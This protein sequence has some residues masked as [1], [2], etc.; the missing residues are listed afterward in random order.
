[1]QDILSVLTFVVPIMYLLTTTFYMTHFFSNSDWSQKAKTPSLVVT[2]L[3]HLVYLSV[4]T[5]QNGY[6]PIASLY[7]VMTMIA[8]TLIA[9]YLIIELSTK[10]D[11]TGSF[12]I[13]F[14][15]IFQGLSSI[16]INQVRF[17]DPALK[18]WV[19]E[20]HI[21]SALLG[22]SGI[23]IAGIYGFLYILLFRQIQANHFGLLYQRLPN[24]EIMERMCYHAVTQGFSYLTIA[25]IAGAIEIPKH[26]HNNSMLLSDPKLIGIML[27]WVAYGVS[28]L[29]RLK[30]GWNGKRMAILFVAG[31]LIMFFSITFFNLFSP[32]FH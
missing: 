10:A 27:I 2:L 26:H 17:V 1:M 29:M 7:Q 5:A 18:N 23:A 3:I 24:L 19:I 16:Y 8:F 25:I 20:L 28:L 13:S 9:S 14:A 4:M 15:T 32:R 30:F 12:V 6:P 11:E 22:Y 21:I 31:L